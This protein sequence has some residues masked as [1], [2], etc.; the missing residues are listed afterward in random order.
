MS[1]PTP[2][3]LSPYDLDALLKEI[4]WVI[5]LK[6]EI[7]ALHSSPIKTRTFP[8]KLKN[9]PNVST[10]LDTFSTY[11]ANLPSPEKKPLWSVLQ[12]FGQQDYWPGLPT[13]EEVENMMMLSINHGAKGITY[14]IYPSTTS[15]N[16]ASGNL[17]KVLQADPAIVFLFGTE[18]IPITG[19]GVEGGGNVDVSA[20]ILDTE[21]GDDDDEENGT[22]AKM[23]VGI[24]NE[25]YRDSNSTVSIT[26]PKVAEGIEVEKVLYG[27]SGWKI[28]EGKLVKVGMK[29]LEHAVA[30][31]QSSSIPS[32]ITDITTINRNPISLRP[33]IVQ[34]A[35]PVE[36][37]RIIVSGLHVL[38]LV[39]LETLSR[40]QLL[41]E[42]FSASEAESTVGWLLD[43][44]GG[45]TANGG[46]VAE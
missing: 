7:L 46:V 45:E 16:V 22:K 6:K 18:P 4:K 5:K 38:F 39:H 9:A 13:A 15:V 33:A 34:L 24:A 1:I 12:A 19:L 10:H 29:G 2:H 26:L 21:D 14:W 20:W 11:Q 17:A 30:V 42:D 41:L 35:N 25:Q 43:A 32:A 31:K 28:Q 3:V 44:E 40:G 37:I 27:D 23:M 36:A 8:L